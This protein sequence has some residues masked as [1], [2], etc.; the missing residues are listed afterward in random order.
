MEYT[1]I[2]FVFILLM[3]SDIENR[4]LKKKMK[5]QEKRINELYEI[6]GNPQ[7]SSGWISDEL[8]MNISDLKKKSKTVE[9]VKILRKQ[10]TMSLLEAKKYVDDL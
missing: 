1:A 2:L 8:K 4:N 7:L 9:A 3:L 5:V 10:T 6:T